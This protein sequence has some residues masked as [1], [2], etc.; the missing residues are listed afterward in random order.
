MRCNR[1]SSCI[2]G[3]LV[4]ALAV[5]AAAVPAAAVPATT[6]ESRR[7]FT[8]FAETALKVSSEH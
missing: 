4:L 2:L 8:G 3:R 1:S 7:W 6:R 5:P